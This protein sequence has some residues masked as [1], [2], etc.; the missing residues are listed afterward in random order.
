MEETLLCGTYY[1]VT[2]TVK[3]YSKVMFVKLSPGE[4]IRVLSLL[5]KMET[6]DYY[7]NTVKPTVEITVHDEGG[8]GGNE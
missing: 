8:N 6:K 5:P 7:E 4:V 3:S 1:D 2:I